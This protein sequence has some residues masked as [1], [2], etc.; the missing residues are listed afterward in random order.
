MYYT[1]QPNICIGSQTLKDEQKEILDAP[2]QSCALLILPMSCSTS[3]QKYTGNKL[4]ES[5]TKDCWKYTN[6]QR[7]K[8]SYKKSMQSGKHK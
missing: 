5:A 8:G 7:K 1:G 6:V 2:K 3:K 4:N